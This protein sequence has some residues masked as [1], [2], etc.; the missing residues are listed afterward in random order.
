MT[1]HALDL[2]A[3]LPAVYRRKDAAQGHPLRALLE[4]ISEQVDVVKEDIDGLWDDMFI[5]TCADWVIPYIS[6]LVGATPLRATEEKHRA[7]VARTIYYRRRKGTLPMLEELLRD[8]TGWTAHAVEFFE[9]MGWSQNLNHLRTRSDATKLNHGSPSTVDLR[10]LDILNRIGGPFD[11]TSHSADFRPMDRA[12]GRHHTSSVGFFV[13]RLRSYPVAGVTAR[14]SEEPPYGY[15]FNPLGLSAPLFVRAEREANR[16]GLVTELNVPTPIRPLAFHS[17]LREYLAEHGTNGPPNSVLYGP[18]R[19]LSVAINGTVVPPK[20]L[21]CMDLSTWKRPTTANVGIDVS[22]GRL[23]VR[24][25]RHEDQVIVGYSYGLSGDLGGGPYDRSDSVRTWLDPER[26]PPTWQRG[27]S[28]DHELSEGDP[29]RVLGSLREAMVEWNDYSRGHPEEFGIIALLDS[30][31]YAESLTGEG[32]IEIPENARLA[33]VAANW[34]R[35]TRG[36]LPPARAIGDLSP[37]GVRP[38]I[39]GNIEVSGTGSERKPGEIILDGLLLEGRLSVLAGNL[40]RLRIRHCTLAPRTGGLMVH[41]SDREDRQNSQLR[42]SI[43]RSVTGPLAVPEGVA[44]LH[45]EDSIIDAL[46]GTPSQPSI[47]GMNEDE[48]DFDLPGPETQLKRVTIIG[49]VHVKELSLASEVI[50][51]RRVQSERRQLGC[52]RF[53][54]VPED[55]L[56]PRRY[57]CQPDLALDDIPETK[58]RVVRARLR[59]SFSSTRFGDPA[60]GQ[61][62]RNCADEIRYGAEGGGEMGAFNFLQQPQRE[63]N[64]FVRL[65]EYLPFGLNPGVI[66]VT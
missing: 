53:S 41:T 64:L 25:G 22:L 15:H 62:G 3:M 46:E 55:S 30:A 65:T 8:V 16:W 54:Y 10:S 57:E 9:N 19:S 63:E 60:Y 27:V 51:M 40:D 49:S 18:G 44:G 58:K 1:T 29:D 24:G 11:A 33:I 14:R 6:D 36:G 13:W 12:H 20:D 38:H 42:V 45:V 7:D 56:T 59:P 35:R 31:T 43:H 5:E 34:P 66:Y 26:A 17:D 32:A 28:R 47:G 21:V 61:L 39:R 23:V 2:Y 50:F 4:I 52:V 37:E 48:P